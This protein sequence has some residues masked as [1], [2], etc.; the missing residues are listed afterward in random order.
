MPTANKHL[1]KVRTPVRYIRPNYREAVERPAYPWLIE[2]VGWAIVSLLV[3]F[4]L[5]LL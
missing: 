2:V 1:A 4:I 3:Y 5:I